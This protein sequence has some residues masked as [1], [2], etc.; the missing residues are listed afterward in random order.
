MELLILLTI[1]LGIGL[2]ISLYFNYN[3]FKNFNTLEENYNELEKIGGEH[4]KFILSLRSKVLQSNS[5]LRQID[6]SG[7]FESDDE[8]GFFF[9]ELKE[10]ISDISN[11]F[12][13]RE[14][15]VSDELINVINQ[16]TN[17]LQ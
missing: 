16:R 10:I 4:E 12:D 11:Y 13:I 5:Q 7:S 6:R 1:L 3:L 9:K 2:T 8:V 15:A 17:T 14:E